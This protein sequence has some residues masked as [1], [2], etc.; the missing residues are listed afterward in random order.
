MYEGRTFLEL[1]FDVVIQIWD[2]WCRLWPER[3]AM[4]KKYD[5][6]SCAKC[7]FVVKGYFS[8]KPVMNVDGLP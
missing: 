8:K 5:L 6:S 2:E 4:L 7:C 3:C 1:D